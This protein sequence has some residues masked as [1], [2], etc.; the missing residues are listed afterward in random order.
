MKK[1]SLNSSASIEEGGHHHQG[2]FQQ[3]DQGDQVS[4]ECRREKGTNTNGYV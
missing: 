2:A 3:N 1:T 4:L